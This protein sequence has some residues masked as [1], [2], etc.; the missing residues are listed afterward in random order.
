MHSGN[1]VAINHSLVY[2]AQAAHAFSA[3]IKNRHCRC[4]D[5]S[6]PTKT[7]QEITLKEPFVRLQD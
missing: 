5:G 1:W 2:Y 3:G 4:K 7:K 6:H